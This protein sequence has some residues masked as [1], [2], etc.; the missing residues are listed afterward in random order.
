MLKN[1]L[2]AALAALM[3][4]G[5]TVP[6]DL[7]RNLGTMAQLQSKP[8]KGGGK[9]GQRSR[10]YISRGITYPFSSTRQVERQQRQ[11]ARNVAK[12]EARVEAELVQIR[13]R[14]GTVT[15]RM[16]VPHTPELHELPREGFRVSA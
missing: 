10:S 13:H 15:A 1:S 8:G 11:H 6:S 12:R 16:V 2:P 14:F 7:Q 4:S 3:M 5:A 9:A